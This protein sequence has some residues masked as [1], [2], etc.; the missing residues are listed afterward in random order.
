[1]FHFHTVKYTTLKLYVRVCVCVSMPNTQGDSK[2]SFGRF[3]L[4]KH[5]LNI[6][7]YL[8]R[9]PKIFFFR[10]S[11][12]R[13]LSEFPP[14]KS[15]WS[16]MSAASP[17]SRVRKKFTKIRESRFFGKTVGRP[18]MSNH[19]R[20]EIELN[21]F[22]NKNGDWRKSKS[23]AFTLVNHIKYLSLRFT[24]YCKLFYTFF[25]RSLA[26]TDENIFRLEMKWNLHEIK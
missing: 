6:F 14:L 2:N 17:F 20:L 4:H 21:W 16:Q 15:I 13:S 18:Q 5:F 19:N 24:L 11:L 8:Y 26:L 12:F 7:Q 3:Q 9:A 10:F 22:F 25:A 23:L 1:M